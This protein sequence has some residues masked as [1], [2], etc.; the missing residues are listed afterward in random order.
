MEMLAFYFAQY[1]AINDTSILNIEIQ[2]VQLKMAVLILVRFNYSYVKQLHMSSD[3]H[4]RHRK[5]TGFPAPWPGAANFQWSIYIPYIL[6]CFYFISPQITYISFLK[7][8]MA[9]SRCFP[10]SYILFLIIYLTHF[11]WSVKSQ[12]EY[13]ILWEADFNCF[14]LTQWI[15]PSLS[16]TPPRTWTLFL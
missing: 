5:L 6:S 9:C 7:I 3:Y 2:L 16:C 14:P 15:T 10:Y 8:S 13:H 4:I 12:L 1:A 11:C